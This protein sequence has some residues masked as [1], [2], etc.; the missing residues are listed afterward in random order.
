MSIYCT[1]LTIYHGNKLPPFYIGYSTVKK[2]E[3]GYHGTVCSKEY[4]D[5]WKQE[6]TN[7]PHLF[8]TKILSKHTLILEAQQ[9]EQT[10]Q[11]QCNVIYN[12]LYVNKAIGRY[13]DNKGKKSPQQSI[14]M[15]GNTLWTKRKSNSNPFKGI[16]RS[17][18][19]GKEKDKQLRLISKQHNTGIVTAKDVNTGFIV[20]VTKEEFINR[21]DLVGLRTGTKSP[22][23]SSLNKNHPRWN[24]N[25]IQPQ[26]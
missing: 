16:P 7:N 21:K 18:T 10:L 17:K 6:L 3:K 8:T 23:L 22:W 14:R 20:K 4:K 15:K 25:A 2:V 11:K 13:C 1:Y 26:S 12:P 5:I 24:T 9:K 19:L